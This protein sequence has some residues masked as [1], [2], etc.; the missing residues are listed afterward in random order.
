M[1]IGLV[2]D[3]MK[4]LQFTEIRDL[5]EQ[6]RIVKEE[7]NHLVQ[8][9]NKNDPENV[10]AEASKLC[11]R[12]SSDSEEEGDEYS[13]NNQLKE[14]SDLKDSIKQC[15]NRETVY[16]LEIKR[17][18][19]EVDELKELLLDVE[20]EKNALVE[21]SKGENK[22]L[23]QDVLQMKSKL[24]DSE[25]NIK[26]LNGD[27]K[28]LKEL[29]GEAQ[30]SLNCTQDELKTVSSELL[31]M[32]QHV[33]LKSGDTQN[34]SATVSDNKEGTKSPDRGSPKECYKLMTH[35]KEQVRSLKIIIDKTLCSS[36]VTGSN[37]QQEQ[38]IENS[39]LK[40]QLLKLQSLLSTKREQIST[41]RTVLK[42]NKATYEVALANLKS[43]YENDKAIQTEANTQLKRQL[44]ALRS[45]C[46]TFASLRSM[47]AT[48]CEEYL[49]Q[50]SDMQ[51]T[52][53]AAEEERGTL[54]TLLKQAIHQKIALT[55]RLEEFELARERLRQ[56]TK[57]NSKLGGKGASK[58]STPKPVTRV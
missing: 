30:A 8:Q 32:H 34:S 41:L 40:E 44:K 17:L 23:S 16:Q 18:T 51:K 5:E 3:L 10:V 28:M 6:L 29:A 25:N 57:K 1:F 45:E 24:R 7:K 21:N 46:L 50:L 56:F 55:Q 47:F 43:R 11:R 13:I 33:S 19:D 36:H 38:V 58:G 54:N 35:V 26:M 20:N 53:A 49:Q 4:E 39:H 37:S 27:I 52:I 31:K 15:R 22:L 12:N 42:A 14:L 9:L 48:R 2:D